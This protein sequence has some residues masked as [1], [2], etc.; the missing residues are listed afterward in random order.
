MKKIRSDHNNLFNYFAH[1]HNDLSKA[2][3]KSCRDFFNKGRVEVTYK[4]AV[5]TLKKKAFK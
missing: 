4:N 2:Y 5:N 3:V 1:N